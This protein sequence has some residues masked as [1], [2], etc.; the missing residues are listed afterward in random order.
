M[1]EQVLAGGVIEALA[2]TATQLQDDLDALQA[3]ADQALAQ[4][5]RPDGLDIAA[6][7]GLPPAILTRVIKSWAETGG[8]GPLTADHIGRMTRLV[9]HWHGQHGVD[10]PG[11]FRVRRASGRLVLILSSST[12][13]RILREH[14]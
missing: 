8:A 2:R 12:T 5:Y 1:L 6:L 14:S 4:S 3:L 9:T 7:D 11:G 13:G 10:V